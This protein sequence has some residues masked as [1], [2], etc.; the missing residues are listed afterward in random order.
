MKDRPL[1][2]VT[3]RFDYKQKLMLGKIQEAD[4][5]YLDH[6]LQSES[7]L[8]GAQALVIR[9]QTRVDQKLLKKAPSLRFVVTATS[10][11]DHIDLKATEK[12]SIRSFHVPETQV[13]SVAE[14]TFLMI[15]ASCRKFN[16]AAWQIQ[17]NQWNR[18][19]LL[20]E[21][22]VGKNL[23]IIGL[24]RV[25]KQVARI[26]QAFGMKVLAFDPYIENHDPN[27]TMLG[28]EEL[29]KSSHVV[30]LHVPKTKKT[31]KMINKQ[32]LQWM[33]PYAKLINLSRGDVINQGDLIW[34][35]KKNPHFVA[36]LDVFEKEPLAQD[37][38]LPGLNNVILSPHIGACT[39]EAFED[40]SRKAL[41]KAL[42]L[43]RNETVDG[44][45]PPKAP[46]Y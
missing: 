43:L 32:S 44:Q 26:A 25:G 29:M 3:G 30:T 5:R 13:V 37:A 23:G 16:R 9:S 24:G 42:A 45:L 7:L 14:L 20:G 19:E 38:P 40:S 41:K 35:L 8:A 15:L 21:S 10:G 39:K 34:H 12:R 17:K 46:W 4:C 22:L 31:C 6:P 28:F 33:S 18:D 1:V 27:V 2:L 36:G 11:F